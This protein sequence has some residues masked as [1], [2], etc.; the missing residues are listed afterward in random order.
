MGG[1]TEKKRKS[2]EAKLNVELKKQK[3]QATRK[4]KGNE[5]RG[6]ERGIKKKDIHTSKE[7]WKNGWGGEQP[8]RKIKG[9][10]R[11]IDINRSRKGRQQESKK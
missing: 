10:Q 7:R 2:M 5:I 4:Q 6:G 11:D 3:K 8:R 1:G 9:K